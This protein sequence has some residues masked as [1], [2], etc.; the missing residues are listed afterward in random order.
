MDLRLVEYV[1][2][3][4]LSIVSTV[5][6]ARVLYRNGGRFLVDVLHDQGLAD[7]VN[8]LLVVGFYLV[9]LG[10]VALLINTTDSLASAADVVRA[11]VTRVGLVLLLLGLMHFVNL[12]VLNRMRRHPETG[13]APDWP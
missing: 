1:V 2:Y 13:P 11:V 5:W 4:L 3:L 9:S 6:V 12:V 7:S 8:R 10:G